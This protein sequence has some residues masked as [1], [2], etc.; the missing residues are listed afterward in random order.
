MFHIPPESEIRLAEGRI[1][2]SYY[3]SNKIPDVLF[4][5][6]DQSIRFCYKKWFPHYSNIEPQLRIDNVVIVSFTINPSDSTWG[7]VWQIKIG[8]KTLVTRDEIVDAKISNI[9]YAL[10]I[11]AAFAIIGAIF[12]IVGII[13]NKKSRRLTSVLNR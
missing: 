13:S 2:E 6:K 8:G 3:S 1:V 10:Y 5:L 11:T 4:R 7:D 9:Q 12:F